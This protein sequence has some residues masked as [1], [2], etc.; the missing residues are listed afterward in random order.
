[1]MNDIA[2]MFSD[3]DDK[4]EGLEFANLVLSDLRAKEL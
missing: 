2:Q 3:Y 4:A 1:M